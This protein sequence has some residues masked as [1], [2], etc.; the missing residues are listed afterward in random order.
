MSVPPKSLPCS[1]TLFPVWSQPTIPTGWIPMDQAQSS[2]F[3]MGILYLGS[4]VNHRLV[5]TSH[6]QEDGSHSAPSAGSWS[7]IKTPIPGVCPCAAPWGCCARLG[8]E[9]APSCS[10]CARVQRHAWSILRSRDRRCPRP[11]GSGPPGAAE[12]ALGGS[13]RP[14]V[15]VSRS[16]NSRTREFCRCWHGLSVCMS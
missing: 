11:G 14:L 3:R 5:S 16:M 10:G 9:L 1:P 8:P 7:T 6:G 12:A 13:I 4:V 2:S 15:C